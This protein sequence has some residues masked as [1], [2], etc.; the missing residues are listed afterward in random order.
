MG[1]PLRAYNPSAHNGTPLWVN[2][3]CRPKPV[4]MTSRYAF[5]L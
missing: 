3:V 5:K 1:Q 2:K 4:P